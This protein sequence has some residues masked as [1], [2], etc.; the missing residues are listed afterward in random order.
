MLAL[1]TPTK[2]RP[3][4]LRL[5]KDYVCRMADLCSDDVVHIVVDGTSATGH[6]RYL[7]YPGHH[8]DTWHVENPQPTGISP[9]RSLC[10]NL[11]V[12]L[13]LMVTTY[14]SEETLNVAVIE[15]DDWYSPL[16]AQVVSDELME[17]DLVGEYEAIYYHL[18]TRSWQRMDNRLHASL[19]A[20]AW[21]H[22]AVGEKIMRLIEHHLRGGKPFVDVAIWRELEGVLL[23]EEAPY[24]VGLKGLW[25]EPGIGS[26]HRRLENGDRDEAQLADLIGADM[27][28]YRKILGPRLRSW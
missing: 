13:E 18:P 21:N 15:D 28:N 25:G 2:N 23:R 7:S 24:V 11:R 12:G 3:R 20:T 27:E 22:H 9:A 26:G 8:H 14:G 17:H 19:C 6:R 10:D 16:W 1:I 5:C 4:A